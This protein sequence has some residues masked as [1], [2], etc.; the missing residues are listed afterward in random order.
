MLSKK[1]FA[2][3]YEAVVSLRRGMVWLN[4]GRDILAPA[5]PTGEPMLS[6][7]PLDPRG[8]TG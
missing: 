8:V 7:K 1:R 4:A 2:V 5:D 6:V 3:G